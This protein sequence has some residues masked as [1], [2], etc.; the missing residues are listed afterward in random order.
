MRGFTRHKLR[1]CIHLLSFRPELIPQK[2]IRRFAV[3]MKNLSP[4]QK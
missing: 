4:E 1:N 2:I 3:R